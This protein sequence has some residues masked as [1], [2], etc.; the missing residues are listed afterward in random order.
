MKKLILS[1]MFLLLF[2]NVNYAQIA[3]DCPP[4]KPTEIGAIINFYENNNGKIKHYYWYTTYTYPESYCI[5]QNLTR[6]DGLK[7]QLK[8]ALIK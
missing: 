3:C 5:P 4:S 1:I 2:I 8:N 6:E 7:P